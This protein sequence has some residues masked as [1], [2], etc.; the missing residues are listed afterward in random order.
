ML[1][2]TVFAPIELRDPTGQ[3]TGRSWASSLA[4]AD[5]SGVDL[6]GADLRE[7]H[8]FG[9]N[10]SRAKQQ[11]ADLQTSIAEG[12]NRDGAILYDARFPDCKE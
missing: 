6:T 10:L 11:R 8:F 7:A 3:T 9:A 5:L 12:A 1:R 2:N 4:N